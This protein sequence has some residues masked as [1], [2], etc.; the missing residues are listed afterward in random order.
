M[1]FAFFIAG[2]KWHSR[3]KLLTPTF[4]YNILEEFLPSI[5]KHCKILVDVLKKELTNTTGFDLKPYAKLAAF[6]IIGNTAF[7]YEINSQKNSEME[8]V[9]A[10]DE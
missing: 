7:G 3:R 10:I 6:D 4:H 1:I 5:Q 9:K 8:Y 2:D